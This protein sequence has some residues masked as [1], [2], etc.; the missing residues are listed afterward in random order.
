MIPPL[1]ATVVV[2]VVGI[3]VGI[4]VWLGSLRPRPE[5]ARREIERRHLSRLDVAL[6]S[7]GPARG[8]D[9]DIV[10]LVERG[11]VRAE[12]GRLSAVGEADQHDPN[13]ILLLA[14]VRE[15]GDAGLDAVRAG[16]DTWYGL[17]LHRLIRRG[18]IVSP[19]RVQASPAI[20]WA[21]TMAV[22]ALLSFWMMYDPPRGNPGAWPWLLSFGAWVVVPLVQILLWCRQPGY[23]GTDPRSRLGRDVIAALDAAI[24]PGTSQADR[25]AIGG[26]A[27]MT[28][29]SLRRHIIGDATDS[30]WNAKPW[31]KREWRAS[32]DDPSGA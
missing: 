23:H 20:L 10:D 32:A 29:A 15:S 4:A 19:D 30:E 16:T 26:L 5:A 1:W 21:P 14:T 22:L 17:S 27:A 13:E 18:L 7:G 31:R 3:G 28:D 12:Q 2:S 11:I 6:V 24:T 8:L 9:S 25:V